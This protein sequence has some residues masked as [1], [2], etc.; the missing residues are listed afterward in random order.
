MEITIDDAIE[1]I[2]EYIMD[3]I[4]ENDSSYTSYNFS[5]ICFKKYN[6]NGE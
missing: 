6:F 5:E 2:K 3:K 4:K 1:S